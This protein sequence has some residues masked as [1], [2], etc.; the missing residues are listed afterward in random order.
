MSPLALL[1]DTSS[2]FSQLSLAAVAAFAFFF[3]TKYIYRVTFHPLAAFPGP[4]LAALTNLYGASY[5]LHPYRSYC[6]QF[7]DLHEKYGLTNV[8][9]TNNSC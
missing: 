1:G 8:P 6:K 3:L 9:I 2:Y 5:D 4:R 7:P